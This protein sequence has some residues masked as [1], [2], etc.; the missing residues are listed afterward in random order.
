MMNSQINVGNI[1]LTIVS[2][3]R[4]R[5]DGGNMFGVIPRAMWERKMPPD[6]MNRILLETNCVLVRTSESLGLIDTGYGG[7]ASPKFRL[8]QALEDGMPLA[9]NLAAVGV[10]PN[11]IDWVVLTH[12][13]ADHA[14][15]ATLRNDDG[16]LEPMFARARHFVQQVE[17][18]DAMSGQPELAGAYYPDDFAP[19]E[20]AGLVEFIDGDAEIA[21][22]VTTQLTGGHTRGHQ[23]V[24]IESAGESAVCLADI[25]PTA[26][27][28]PV[29]W[30]MAYDQFPLDVRRK[31]PIV[32]NDIGENQRIALFCHD[33]Q[34][35]A[36]RLTRD[37][38]EWT[39]A[40]PSG[41]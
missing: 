9:R 28:L 22:G 15:G 6:E 38:D 40:P 10:S 19:L 3:G 35:L 1:Q 7:K 36:A 31:K 33:P 30:S 13:H 39:V 2:G 23:I 4:L 21:P 32:L 37:A 17:W 18:H 41:T 12:L 16:R 27:H 25:C 8:R 14:G 11:E 34:V 20:Q 24:R 29:F 5:V 26:A